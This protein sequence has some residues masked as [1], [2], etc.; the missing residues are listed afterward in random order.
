MTLIRYLM[1]TDL[2]G[3]FNLHCMYTFNLSKQVLYNRN[4]S[5][6]EL[7]PLDLD[8]FHC[9]LSFPAIF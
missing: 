3:G 9:L 7:L 5:E 2:V 1:M 4:Q 6:L 8:F